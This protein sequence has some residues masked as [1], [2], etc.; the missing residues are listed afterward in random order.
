M[1]LLWLVQHRSCIAPQSCQSLLPNVHLLFHGVHVHILHILLHSL[2]LSL[3]RLRRTN[4][5]NCFFAEGRSRCLS[6]NCTIIS[7]S[8][9][10][11]SSICVQH[12]WDNMWRQ[13]L[14]SI[15]APLQLRRQRGLQRR[16]R[17][18]TRTRGRDCGGDA[19]AQSAANHCVPQEVGVRPLRGSKGQC[20][21]GICPTDRR[22]RCDG[23]WSSV[24]MWCRP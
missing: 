19:V 6:A 12:D 1:T 7:T 23:E 20:I 24:A 21:L 3:A 11:L 22:G 8:P 9:S 17:L 2:L 16:I 10:R 14:G 4:R 15:A 5:V 18:S 13:H